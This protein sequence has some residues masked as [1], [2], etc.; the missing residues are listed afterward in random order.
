[1]SMVGLNGSVGISK[2]EWILFKVLEKANL[3][4]YYDNF[5]SQGG[6]DVTQLCEAS[7]D[8][9]LEIMALVG[10]SSRPLHV[11]RLQKVLKEWISN[12]DMF[13]YNQMPL[14]RIG[15]SNSSP[16][17]GSLYASMHLSNQLMNNCSPAF[18]SDASLKSISHVPTHSE[19]VNKLET[20]KLPDEQ[21]H[22]I[23]SHVDAMACN[24]PLF[25]PKPLNSKKPID[26]QIEEL[27]NYPD[28]HPDKNMLLRKYSAIYGRFDSKRRSDKL[29]NWHEMCI[30]EAAGQ[31]C[32]HRPTLVTRRE[33]LFNLARQIVKECT[34]MLINN[35]KSRPASQMKKSDLR[36]E[37]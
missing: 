4:Q 15:H 16:F 28:D 20:Q 27:L 7:E 19:V 21:I 10:M 12:P 31:L 22:T 37:K 2:S 6:D 34:P 26:L 33:D 11:R 36:D 18:T 30:N 5:I 13:G 32:I 29:L 9:F 17:H 35:H 23:R 24:L 8:E 14:N 1:M 3:L 25:A